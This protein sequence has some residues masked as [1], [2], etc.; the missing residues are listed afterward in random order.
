MQ[1]RQRTSQI[2]EDGDAVRHG[3]GPMVR[4][5]LGSRCSGRHRL[6][7]PGPPLEFANGHR[8]LKHRMGEIAK[9]LEA[10]RQQHRIG[11]VRRPRVQGHKK[12]QTTLTARRG[13]RAT[14]VER[15]EFFPECCDCPDGEL[16]PEPQRVTCHAMK[17]PRR[18]VKG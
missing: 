9:T 5:L 8:E 7:H 1:R 13:E 3:E 15:R 18:T 12:R 17:L 4:N 2:T 11:T 6:N 14:A 10:E 16:K